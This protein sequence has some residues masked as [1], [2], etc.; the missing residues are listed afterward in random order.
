MTLHEERDVSPLLTS[1]A[2][3]TFDLPTGVGP[4][5]RPYTSPFSRPVVPVNGFAI[6]TGL[7]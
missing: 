3:R 4:H 1:D 2:D 7:V 5:R 6:T